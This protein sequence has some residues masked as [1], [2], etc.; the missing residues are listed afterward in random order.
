V[1][2]VNL[3]E[4]ISSTSCKI[5]LCAIRIAEASIVLNGPASQE[6]TYYDR[7]PWLAVD[8]NYLTSSCTPNTYDRPW[9]SVDLGY[10]QQ[11]KA[12]NVTNDLNTQQRKYRKCV[13]ETSLTIQAKKLLNI[14][15]PSPP[16]VCETSH[17]SS[18]QN[19]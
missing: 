3:T 14:F 4:A 7:D 12:V 8:G 5:L 15:L 13:L 19:V 6:G 16:S 11:V 1:F 10:P 17:D 18:Q 2:Y 9:W